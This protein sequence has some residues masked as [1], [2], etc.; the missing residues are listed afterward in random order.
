MPRATPKRC[1]QRS[2]GKSTIHRHGYC[3]DHAGNAGWRK[4]GNEQAA[5]GKRVHH[6]SEWRRLSLHV[7]QLAGHICIHHYLMSPSVIIDGPMITEHIIPV[8]KGGSNELSNL[9]CFC[10]D[11]AKA[12]TAWE[13]NKSI[14]EVLRRYKHTSIAAFKGVGG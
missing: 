10:V 4:Y 1:R 12:K 7:K 9:S 14:N 13:R 3:D 5:I 2:C 11:C 8:A 6:T